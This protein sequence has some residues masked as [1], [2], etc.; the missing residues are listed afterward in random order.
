MV[1]IKVRVIQSF[2]NIDG[3][4]GFGCPSVGLGNFLGE[5]LSGKF[6]S[7]SVPLNNLFASSSFVVAL[8]VMGRRSLMIFDELLKE[9]IILLSIY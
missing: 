7:F 9:I 2:C 3:V 8:I 4:W 5:V 6:F 1:E